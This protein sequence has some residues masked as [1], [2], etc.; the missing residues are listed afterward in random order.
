MFHIWTRP[1][2]CTTLHA[3]HCAN[4]FCSFRP[5][6]ALSIG[7]KLTDSGTAIVRCSYR[8]GGELPDE[9]V[10]CGEL[11]LLPQH[12]CAECGGDFCAQ[13]IIRCDFCGV[14]QC[15]HCGYYH[16]KACAYNEASAS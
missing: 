2:T 8:L 9:K 1:S 6:I 16:A 11:V 14:L 13:H 7:R 12:V 10:V 4:N 15:T 3:A 5:R